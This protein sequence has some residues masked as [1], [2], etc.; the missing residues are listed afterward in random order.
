MEAPDIGAARDVPGVAPDAL[1]AARA[2]GERALTGKDDHAHRGVLARPLERVR[3]LDQRLRAERVANLGPIDR[4][5]GNPVGELVADVLVVAGGAPVRAG[6][7][8]A[9]GGHAPGRIRARDGFNPGR[10][11]DWLA[12]AA[13]EYPDR[14]AVEADDGRLTYAELDARAD[15]LARL[16]RVSPGERVP[17][18]ANSDLAFATLLLQ[19]GADVNA[20]EGRHSAGQL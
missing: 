11:R 12:T 14:L 6:P 5:L 1:V 16:L 2:E 13:D 19:H 7:D 4:D 17:A 8:R 20:R 15:E 10:M 3:D 18:A 9:G